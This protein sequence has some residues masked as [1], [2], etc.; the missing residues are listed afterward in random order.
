MNPVHEH[1]SS[2]KKIE[3][4]DKKK[5]KKKRQNFRKINFFCDQNDLI[6]GQMVLRCFINVGT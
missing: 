1:C 4:K 2:Q 5:I 6:G 3:K